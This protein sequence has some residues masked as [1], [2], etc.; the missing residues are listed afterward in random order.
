VEHTLSGP[1]AEACPAW[2]TLPVAKLPP[3]LP[4][5]SLGHSNPL[6]PHGQ[7]FVKAVSPEREHAVLNVV[8]L[9]SK[10]KVARNASSKQKT[11]V[12]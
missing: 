3:V 2:E 5:A 8:V 6:R 10:R 9:K 11:S 12:C 1:S 7:C 4:P